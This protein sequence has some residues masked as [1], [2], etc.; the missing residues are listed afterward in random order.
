MFL[1]E[2]AL[3]VKADMDLAFPPSSCHPNPSSGV[4][5]HVGAARFTTTSPARL[6]SIQPSAAS[7]F[8]PLP[9]SSAVG[10]GGPN[11]LKCQRGAETLGHP[12]LGCSP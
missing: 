5:E 7:R 1:L 6:W 11:T 9:K 3:P 4:Q 12:E 8:P 2:G 10:C